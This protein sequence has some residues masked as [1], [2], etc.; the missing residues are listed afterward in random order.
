MTVGKTYVADTLKREHYAVLCARR[1][2]KHAV[3]RH[4]PRNLIWG[5]DLA[6]YTDTRGRQYF[7]VMLIE[8]ASRACLLLK[9]LRN[10]SSVTLLG[11]LLAPF[12]QYGR[13]V[14]LR[15][16]NESCWTSRL[17]RLTLWL[18]GIGHQ[19]TTPHCPW[20]NGRVERCIGTL[21]TRLASWVIADGEDLDRALTVARGWYNHLRPHQHLQGRT[22]AE[23]WA[24]VEVFG[25]TPAG[26]TARK[27]WLRNV[28]LYTRAM[29]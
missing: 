15:T 19:R 7:I 10:K 4:L 20:E 1:K 9:R 17:F 22:P 11:S 14:Y 8:H 3:P 18:L 24:G 13:P 25:D 5:L 6:A 28:R 21:K 27:L 12:R 16:D 23:A 29:G 26:K 2:M